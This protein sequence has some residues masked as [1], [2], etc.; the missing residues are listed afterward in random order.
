MSDKAFCLDSFTLRYAHLASTIGPCTFFLEKGRTGV[1]CGPSGSGKTTLLQSLAGLEPNG[2][3]P[4]ET[5]GHCRVIS[6]VDLLFEK[7]FLQLLGPSVKDELN[8]AQQSSWLPSA[9]RPDEGER[10]IEDFSL[11]TLWDRLVWE[12]S[13]GERQKLALACLFL[14]SPALLLLDQ[15]ASSLDRAGRAALKGAIGRATAR[16]ASVLIAD[17][18]WK[19]I[20]SSTVEKLSLFPKAS[21]LPIGVSEEGLFDEPGR[22]RSASAET[23][24]NFEGLEIRRGGRTVVRDISGQVRRGEIIALVGDNGSGKTSLLL[25]MAGL[26]KPGG[27]RLTRFYPEGRRFRRARP[28]LMLQESLWHLSG[29]T[30]KGE[31]AWAAK[32]TSAKWGASAEPLVSLLD[33]GGVLERPG[34]L[35]SRGEMQRLAIAMALLRKGPILCLDEPLR[36]LWDQERKTIGRIFQT[37]RDRGHSLLVASPSEELLPWADQVWRLTRGRMKICRTGSDC[38][39]SA[40]PSSLA[41]SGAP[42]R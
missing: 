32:R 14:R 39:D 9:A 28:T 24:I 22:R 30:V 26:L 7:P 4:V 25:T 19:G 2:F 29:K 10:L 40:T 34:L 5:S 41:P 8:A 6:P 11:D 33:L 17:P 13:E 21:S 3:G 31:L 36:F 42:Q 23:V 27:G 12:L 20:S 38:D 18:D 37:A 35:L 1:L 15:P 16:G